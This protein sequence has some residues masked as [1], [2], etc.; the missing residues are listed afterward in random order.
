METASKRF[1]SFSI[2]AY[3]P[4]VL[5]DVRQRAS[6]R[7]SIRSGN[8]FKCFRSKSIESKLE[9]SIE[10]SLPSFLTSS[11]L[12]LYIS[13][14]IF[15]KQRVQAQAQ[16]R[17]DGQE[18]G[19]EEG[20]QEK[21]KRER[22][23]RC[24][25]FLPCSLTST[26]S[27]SLSDDLFFFLLFFLFFSSQA[28]APPPAT[29]AE[30]N[31]GT[32]PSL[33][34]EDE[35]DDVDPAKFYEARVRAVAAA[36]AAGQNPYPHTYEA[37]LSLPEYVEKFQSTLE[38]GQ[39]ETEQS[40]SLAGRVYAKRAQGKLV[41]FDLKADGVKVQVMADARNFGCGVEGFPAAIT[42]FKRGDIVGVDGFP[43]EF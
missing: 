43:G 22:N 9:R 6:E 27:L 37:T 25:F 19:R 18:K 13:P 14:T 4:L 21:K 11:S 29:K 7:E 24:F 17:R 42:A 15:S 26:S 32:T 5:S 12:S 23:R 38:P 20:E 34:E 41:F 16:G 40:A 30:N 31:G 36:R 35:G 8:N 10:C 3:L 28:N 33:V 1:L 2:R 39:Q